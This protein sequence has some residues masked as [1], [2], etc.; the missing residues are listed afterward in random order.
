MG[1]V[2][3]IDLRD[4]DVPQGAIDAAFAW[5]REVDQRFS[6]FKLE[7]QISRLGRGEVTV[8]QCHRDVATVLELCED[9]RVRSGGAFNAWRARADGRLD[10]SGVVK[11]WAVER[12][13]DILQKAGARNVAISAGGDIIARGEPEPG[14]RWRTGIR[15]PQQ[16]DAVAAVIAVTNMAVATSG[17]YERGR[18]IVDAR[19]GRPSGELLSLTIAGPRMTWADAYATA[20]FA[21]GTEGIGWVSEQPGYSVYGITAGGVVRYDEGFARFLIREESHGG[22]SEHSAA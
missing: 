19:T 3:S 5:L 18:H 17:S 10:P 12:A 4:R 20:A 22:G 8:A 21:M 16:A 13:A 7:S 6:T 2:V 1:T 9:L 11:G 15:H 14:R